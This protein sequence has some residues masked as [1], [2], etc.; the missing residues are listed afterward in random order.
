MTKTSKFT[1]LKTGAAPVVLG[2][3]MMSTPAFAQDSDELAAASTANQPSIVV[4][5]TRITNPN[6]E[7]SSPIQVVGQ[8]EIDYRQA[9]NAEEL[10]GELPG[11]AAGTNNSVNN[12]SNGTSTLN[13][14]NLSSTRSLVLLDGTRLVPS[15]IL[16]QTDLNIIPIALV[17]RVEIIT[18]G[19]SS[20][21]GA[22]AI[23]GVANF[24]LRRDFEG[25]EAAM[26]FGITERGDGER[27]RG[28]VTLGANFDDGRGNAVLSIGYQETDDVLQASRLIS[29]GAKFGGVVFGS[30]TAV[31][32]TFNSTLRVS[33]DGQDFIAPNSTFNYAPFNY[34]QTPL[35]RYNIFG[36]ARYEVTPGIEVYTRGMFTNSTVSLQLAPSGL[37]GDPF[38]FPLN[39]P[40]LTETQRQQLCASYATPIDPATCTAAGQATGPGDP[41]YI[42]QPTIINRRLVEQ[43]PRQTD[44]VTN[45][46]QLWA[47]VRGDL[48]P[49][50]SYD[51]YATYG[52]SQRTTTRRN[53]GLK[54]RVEQALNATSTTT[55][56]DASNGCFPIN[57]L[58]GGVGTNIDPQAVTFINQPSGFTDSTSL[59]VVNAS[60]NG[61]FGETGFFTETPIGFAVGVEYREYTASRVADVSAG[62]QDEV[63]GTGAPAPT[64][65]GQYDVIEGFAELIVPILEDVPGFYS[66]QAEGGIRVSDYSNTGTNVTWKAG[67]SWEPFEGFRFRGIY[68][69][70]VRSPNIGELFAPVTT[71]LT[72]LPTDPCQTTRDPVTNAVV[73]A[74]PLNDPNL[75][76]ICVAQGAPAGVIGTILQPSAA[77]INAT[78][79]GN[80]DLDVEEAESITIG[81]VAT[82]PQ[83]PGLV[84]S[85][86]YF[87]IKVT[88]AITTPNPGDI[89]TPCYGADAGGG[90]YPNA[91]PNSPA[92]ANIGRNPING[93]L[94]GGGETLGLILQLSN[95]GELETSGIDFRVNYTLP[96]SFGAINW[97]LNGTWTDSLTFNANPANPQNITRECVG[98]FSGNC[99]PI[100]PEW[101]FNLRTT[102]SVDDLVDV[103]LL[104]RW[105]D[106]VT[107]EFFDPTGANGFLLESQAFD[108][109]S[110]FDL[111]VRSNVSENFDVTLSVFNLL[112]R[113]PPETSSFIGSS[114]YNSGN[115]YPT[116]YDTLGRSYSVT[117][118]LRF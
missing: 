40:F 3:A 70:S 91:D 14:R 108:D 45:Q 82:P 44:L 68:S 31:P 97:D 65:N 96:V 79:G 67:G 28:D 111:S 89:L 93:T 8:D 104:W 36:S 24:V 38:I 6:L 46:F 29:Q 50:I 73:H 87:D 56:F 99:E 107:Y 54:S 32:T 84:V 33:P 85:I 35:E 98:L 41:N 21:Y 47:G 62:T 15:T 92:C 117:G 69:V 109:A 75:A 61:T 114:V 42:A 76:Q 30:G 37:F 11:I 49:T 71:G 13:L 52:E 7:Q 83:V 72:P 20:V 77:Q 4:T 55:C 112:D 10:I 74:G 100:T 101:A 80:V 113:D 18:G 86:D 105:I 53:W 19:A 63:L 106:G 5:G 34:F 118:R 9:T 22:D 78:S 60:L 66:L 58:G 48:S 2:I 16:S 103:S 95:L 94:N 81:L 88:G 43:G 115:T 110:Y 26:T 64:F 39:N 17:E 51:V 27:I 12:G 57:L 102:V 116:T 25:V 23:S 90:N 1:Q 59:S